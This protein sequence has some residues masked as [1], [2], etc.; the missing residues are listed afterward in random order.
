MSLYDLVFLMLIATATA[1]VTCVAVLVVACM[2]A[3]LGFGVAYEHDCLP[4]A[5]CPLAPACKW[6]WGLT[7]MGPLLFSRYLFC[8]KM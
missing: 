2:Y 7:S 4:E 6:L 1:A 8:R 5:P 3:C